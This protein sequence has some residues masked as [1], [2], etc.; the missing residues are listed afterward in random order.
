MTGA[1]IAL[2]VKLVTNRKR[3]VARMAPRILLSSKESI[4][5]QAPGRK[6]DFRPEN[7]RG[8]VRN[9]AFAPHPEQR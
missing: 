3:Q 5:D 7:G 1:K 2:A 8:S 6:V 4:F 9:Q